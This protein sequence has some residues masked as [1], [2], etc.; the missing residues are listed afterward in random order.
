MTLLPL[1]LRFGFED[2]LQ[3]DGIFRHHTPLLDLQDL[4]QRTLLGEF[5]FPGR[6]LLGMIL[7]SLVRR[8]SSIIE[9]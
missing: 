8:N 1:N 2:A 3:Q 7:R 9:R 4:D 6:E 5:V